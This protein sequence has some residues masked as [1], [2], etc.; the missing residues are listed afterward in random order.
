MVM[1]PSLSSAISEVRLPAVPVPRAAGV[2]SV[3]PP[4]AIQALPPHAASSG[5][6]IAAAGMADVAPTKDRLRIEILIPGVGAHE[7][8]DGNQLGACYIAHRG[9]GG[10]CEP[11]RGDAED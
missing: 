5:V 3:E 6:V 7:A 8:I 1:E 4:A 2:P 10:L 11:G 9:R